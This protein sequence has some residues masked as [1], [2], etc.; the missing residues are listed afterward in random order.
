MQEYVQSPEGIATASIVSRNNINK[1]IINEKI[2]NNEYIPVEDD[3]LID[4]PLDNEEDNI[5]W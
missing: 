2:K 5:R 4:I 3:W 1:A